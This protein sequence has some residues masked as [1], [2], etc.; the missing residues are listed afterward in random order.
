MELPYLAYFGLKEEPFGTVSSPRY[1]FLTPMHAT[2]LTMSQ[3]IVE[4][5]K[6]LT[7]I[8]G[9]PGMGDPQRKSGRQVTRRPLL[10]AEG[11]GFEPRSPDPESGVLPL[12]DPSP[13]GALYYGGPHC[14]NRYVS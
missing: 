6:G 9:E 4:A 2:A 7:V 5:R 14:A 13:R 3:F 10:V 11:Q 1:L 12:D 8:F